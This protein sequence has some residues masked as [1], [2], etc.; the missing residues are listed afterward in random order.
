MRVGI[1]DR[2]WSTLG[3]GER[4]A[5]TLAEALKGDGDVELI[6]IEPLDLSVLS[7]RLE[8]DLQ[9]ARY[10]RWPALSCD[11]LVPLTRPYDLFINA[12]YGSSMRS[13]AGRSAYL[14][15]F[16]HLLRSRVAAAAQRALRSIVRGLAPWQVRFVG[17]HYD[18]EPG[19][20]CWT[21]P[22]AWLLISPGAFRDGTATIALRAEPIPSRI[23]SVDG[24]IASWSA[25][26]DHL[27]LKVDSP[28]TR[29]VQIHIR[30]EPVVP[31]D[32]G[33][34]DDTRLLGVCVDLGR[35]RGRLALVGRNAGLTKSGRDFLEDYDT[36]LAIS[37]YTQEWTRRRW[38]RE[39][40]LA[41]PPVETGGAGIPSPQAKRPILLSVGRFF[42]GSHHNKKH[43]E[44]LQVFREMCDRGLVPKG[45]E[46]HL[47]GRVHRE[48]P[49]HVA[50]FEE[51]QRLA[52]GYP[53]RILADIPY[54]DLAAEYRA[55]T[56]FWHATGW[57]EDDRRFPE[58][59][60]HFGIT[61]CEA[62]SA[63]CI[64]V[65]IDKAGQKEVVTDGVN[66]YTFLT[67]R[68]LIDKTTSL[69]AGFGTDRTAELIRAAQRSAESYGKKGFID[70][71]RRV[72]LR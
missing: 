59:F 64:P 53:V 9:G 34:A 36:L 4:Y 66:G 46:Y 32:I 5:A 40:V 15:M 26:A 8:V 7:H 33:V 21:G 14:V 18:P 2:Y 49:E 12:T 51:V 35:G 1:Y 19:G 71:A 23:L 25:G 56:I 31:K 72:L 70:R 48:T 28:P 16:P 54:D 38:G 13:E 63:G 41:P 47:A 52:R 6:G 45:W 17:G 3:G 43:I 44:M 11:R 39:S 10:T 67:A 30:A 61:T 58:R 57:G 20:L 65:V 22:D 69:M 24:P 37:E 60:E 50:Y 62:M 42:A 68:E 27:S 29:P 55:A